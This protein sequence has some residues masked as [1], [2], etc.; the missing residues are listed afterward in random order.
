M[1]NHSI[2]GRLWTRETVMGAIRAEA[3]AGHDLSYSCTEKRVPSLVRAAERIFGNW[4]S[5]VNASGFDYDAIRRYRKWT[6]EKVL[7]RIR[8]WHAKGEDLSWRYVSTQ[9]DPPLAAAAL[10]AG[11]FASWVDALA[12][13]GLDPAEIARYRKWTLPRIHEELLSLESCGVPLDRMHLNQR[14]SSLL[15]AIY[16]IGDGLT[17]E[18]KRVLERSR[19]S[20]R[21]SQQLRE[22]DGFPEEGSE[23]PDD[24]LVLTS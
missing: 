16:R 14:A 3:R 7:E 20:E 13:A 17:S 23:L 10:H 6:R 19:R 4:G 12:A 22:W 8:D 5:A 2:S 15:A 1:S 24:L 21:R 18:R 9:L 11:R